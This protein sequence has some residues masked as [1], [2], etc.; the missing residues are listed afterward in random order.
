MK[1]SVFLL[2]V[3]VFFG[4]F[5]TLA[6]ITSSGIMGAAAVACL[7]CGLFALVLPKILARA[8][9]NVWIVAG[10][11]VL[12]ALLIS[13]A[14]GFAKTTSH[15]QT[16]W[17]GVSINFVFLIPLALI[18]AAFLFYS[19]LGADTQRSPSGK[20]TT[21]VLLLGLLLVATALRNLYGFT[22][23]DNTYDSLGYIWL[24]IPF[25]AVLL[26]GLTLLVALPSRTKLAGLLYILILPVLMAVASSQAQRVDFRAV[27]AQRAERIVNAVESFYAREG[28][29]PESLSQLT[30]RDILTLPEPMII[31]GQDWCYESGSDSYR[32]GYVDREHWSDPRLIGRIYKTEGQTSGQSLMCEAEIAALQ[33]DNPD[34]QY[35]Y[36]KESP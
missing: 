31:Y 6:F 8:K 13:T 18:V 24:F 5:A 16:F 9:P 33:Q 11:V 29:Y 32:L 3:T 36:W 10:L 7:L 20:M 19:G 27:T 15:R 1:L 25:C 14:S 4:V 2:V 26:S 34:F 23:W 21:T 22:L 28:H 17:D 12:I 35:S 30:P